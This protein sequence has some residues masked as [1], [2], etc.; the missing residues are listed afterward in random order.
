MGKA[1][2][3]VLASLGGALILLG[4]AGT[5]AAWT[6]SQT[7]T[8]GSIN[9]G[10]LAIVT[11][12]TNTGCGPWTLDNGEQAPYTYTAGDPIVPGDVL[13]RSCAYTVRAT[14]NHLR[15]TVGISAV[16]FSGTN[17]NFGGKLTASV[18]AVKLN[19]TPAASFTESD[20]GATLT[21]SVTVTFNSTADNSTQNL[22]TI[23]DNLTLTATQV[24]A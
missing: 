10:H 1:T 13:T 12:A 15:A 19:G 11:D 7:I 8:G 9:S 21:A 23:F 22:S 16:N 5:L 2:K 17:G 24:H 14:G 4:G 3:G 6:D 18:S 20:N